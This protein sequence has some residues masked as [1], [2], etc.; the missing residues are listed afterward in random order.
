LIFSL[1]PVVFYI[2]IQRYMISGLTAGAVK[3]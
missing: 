1:P 3:G 2:L